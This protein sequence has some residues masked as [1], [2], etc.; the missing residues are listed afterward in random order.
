MGRTFNG[1]ILDI[2]EFEVTD[3]VSIAAAK[4]RFECEKDV[5]P[6]LIFQGED[7]EVNEA[8]TR[9]K[10]LFIDF[11]KVS[12][13]EEANIMELKRVI[14]FTSLGNNQLRVD[15]YECGTNFSESVVLNTVSAKA[16]NG[17]QFK[18]VGP[19]FRLIMRRNRIATSENF[20]QA[21]KQPKLTNVEKKRA[22]KNIYTTEIGEKRAKV[23]IQQQDIQTIANRK[24]K[25]IAY[26]FIN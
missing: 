13:W 4:D 23:F 18:E 7:F 15:N 1:R 14:V 3:F 5:K 8:F 19:S 21:C 2:F 24:F 6:V 9:L 26:L 10:N 11:F 17:V 16:S 25:V 22:K 20:K 12:T